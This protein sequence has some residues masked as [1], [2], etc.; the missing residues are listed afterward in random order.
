[1]EAMNTLN[2]II[3]AH[4]RPRVL[5]AGVGNVFLGDDAFGV[6]VAQRLGDRLL[7]ATI[8]VIDFGIRGVDLAFALLE[9]YDAVILIDA[10]PRGG[11]PGTLYVLEPH[12]DASAEPVDATIEMHT[13]DPVKVMRLAAFMGAP[14]Q[15]VFVIGCEPSPATE[16]ED[17]RDGLS[18]PVLA[19]VND[20]LDLTVQLATQVLKS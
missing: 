14:L 8:R 17:F 10:M 5:I 15:H 19:A 13:M 4:A 16:S 9:P 18:E 11:A 7:P 1:M 6:I 2:P 20:A 3:D 12:V